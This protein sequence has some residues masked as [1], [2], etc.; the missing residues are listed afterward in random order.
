MRLSRKLLLPVLGVLLLVLGSGT[1]LLVTRELMLFEEEAGRHHHL[2]GRVLAGAVAE[3]V[4]QGGPEKGRAVLAAANEDGSNISVRWVSLDAE[5]TSF[6]APRAPRAA[7]V[8]LT[9]RGELR[10]RSGSDTLI[11]YRAIGHPALGGAL[12]ISESLA[13]AREHV[14]RTVVGILLAGLLF[15]LAAVGAT[16]L[17]GTF[18]IGR[19]LERISQAARHIGR[20]DYS[21]RLPDG[22]RDELG[23]LAREVNRMA[24]QLQAARERAVEDAAAREQILE[25]LRHAER[26]TTVGKLASGV[27]HELGT[28]LNV[29][30]ARARQLANDNLPPDQV[31]RHGRII[32]GQAKDMVH[33]IRQLLDFARPRR[34]KRIPEDLSALARSVIDVVRPLADKKGVRLSFDG[35]ASIV[36][37]V[38]PQ[39]IR[40]ALT[41]L[42]INAIQASPSGEVVKVHIA[43]VPQGSGLPGSVRISVSDSGPGIAPDVQGRLFEPFFTTKDV[44][45]GTGLGLSVAYGLMQE[46]G[47]R[48][49]VESTSGHGACFTLVLP[50]APPALFRPSRTSAVRSAPPQPGGIT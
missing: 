50:K 31:Q 39:H 14:N 5:A 26:L 19:P 30:A 34:A 18:I 48:I 17:L 42:V 35:Q 22:A 27:A 16:A 6:V 4:A 41:N 44:G 15:T 7:L 40:Q 25:Q 2:L 49:E 46:Q 45:E 8:A 38:D 37:E 28:P 12:E 3:A 1:A 47:G 9:E 11:S 10:W 29:V 36:R 23:L 20:G 32:H 33:I 43:E 21:A 13:P 24:E